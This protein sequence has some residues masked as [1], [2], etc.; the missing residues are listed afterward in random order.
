MAQFVWI[1]WNLAKI[2][3]HGLSEEEVEHAWHHR[4]DAESWTDPEPG[5]VSFGKLPNGRWIKII[6]RY[7]AIDRSGT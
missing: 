2:D 1:D 6:W 4:Q 5:T 7:N 3:L